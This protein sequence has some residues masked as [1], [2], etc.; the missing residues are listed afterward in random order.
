MFT[1]CDRMATWNWS[2]AS[3]KSRSNICK[4]ASFRS[5]SRSWFCDKISTSRFSDSALARRMILR[6]W[7]RIFN[8]LTL[9]FCASC[10]MRMRSSALAATRC[11]RRCSSVSSTFA[12]PPPPF[13][14]PCNT[15]HHGEAG[16]NRRGQKSGG[17]AGHGT[18]TLESRT[19]SALAAQVRHL[20][21]SASDRAGEVNVGQGSP[22]RGRSNATL[23]R[24]NKTGR[25]TLVGLGHDA[26]SDFRSRRA[27]RKVDGG[28]T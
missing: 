19:E 3:S 5:T 26:I 6:H 1:R 23:A 18:D 9:E 22:P 21:S 24:P 4:M 14:F 2:S 28:T 15:R 8:P 16:K 27:R 12:G 13:P 25:F 17:T 10:S 7:L 20:P 11:A